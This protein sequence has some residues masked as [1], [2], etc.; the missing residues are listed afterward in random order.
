[1]KYRTIVADPPWPIGDF[2]AW[3]DRDRRSERERVLGY[4]PT[5]YPVMT[6]EEIK[7][8]PV[9]ELSDNVDSDAHLYL[10]T[11]D[12]FLDD[13]FDVARAWGFHHAA[14]LVWCKSEM[15]GGLGGIW[16]NNVEFVLFCR[17]PKVTTRPDVLRV[18][19]YLADAAERAGVTRR[20]IDA[21]MGTSDMAGW[22][23]S[24]IEYRCAC[25]SWEQWEQLK[26]LTGAGNELDDLVRE[27]N[28]R[29][30]AY[31]ASPL[32]RAPGR[33]FQWKRGAHS[34]KPEAFIDMVE[35]VSPPPYV[36]LFAR[37]HRLGWDVW[38]N[39]SANTATLE[40]IS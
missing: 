1:M 5:P 2:P 35:Q 26:A 3:H 23:L 17:R 16:P 21:A 15:G 28:G 31:Q 12:Q 10:W 14:T 33:W 38:G 29:K 8:L 9:R 19:T 4:N 32:N 39:E 22:W 13:A 20:K 18:T 27:I 30:G 6:I 40:A 24:R 11:I 36:E 34:A 37:R 7:A 25:P